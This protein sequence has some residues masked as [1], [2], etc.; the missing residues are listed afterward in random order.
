[1]VSGVKPHGVE[2][3]CRSSACQEMVELTGGLGRVE[4]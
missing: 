4:S 3:A 2:I 1:V